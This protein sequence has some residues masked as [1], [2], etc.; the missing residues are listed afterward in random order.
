MKNLLYILFLSFTLFNCNPME[1]PNPVNSN[2]PEF[3]F[4]GNIG[5]TNFNFDASKGYTSFTNFTYDSAGLVT[6]T[7]S[8]LF[9][10]C[11]ACPSILQF[12]FNANTLVNNMPIYNASLLEADSA[13]IGSKVFYSYS[14]DD[15]FQ[16]IYDWE[17]D[18]HPSGGFI[19]AGSFQYNLVD[20]VIS[21]MGIDFKYF[22]KTPGFKNISVYTNVQGVQDTL[23]RRIKV[24]YGKS[25]DTIYINNI[26]S[27]QNVNF[28]SLTDSN[29]AMYWNFGDGTTQAGSSVTHTFTSISK[30]RITIYKVYGTDTFSKDVTIN[31]ANQN[32]PLISPQVVLNASYSV[33]SQQLLP[34]QNLSSCIITHNI[35]GKTYK[36]FKNNSS[37]NQSKKP[38]FNLK[39][40]APF[41]KNPAGQKTLKLIGSVDTY[42]YNV[43][44][45]ADSIKI[46]CDNV[47][48]AVAV[49]N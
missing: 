45:A 47:R 26:D 23:Y 19:G 24:G 6:L 35:S 13:T 30:F 36:S 14:I 11:L 29:T 27:L 46:K 9:D 28:S 5:S 7:G 37:I 20:T 8:F 17:Y 38:I 40:S 31:F 41:Q 15:T 48:I 33:V 39:Y 34:R 3:S 22:F 21:N 43:N 44:N 2:T 25:D 42:L 16:N 18:I 49:P 10:S 1:I 4:A 12:D 32:A